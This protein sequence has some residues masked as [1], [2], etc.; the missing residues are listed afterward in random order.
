MRIHTET[1]IVGKEYDR[2]FLANL[3]G[4]RSFQALG[5]GVVTP[6]GEKVIILFITKDKQEALEQY[7]D[8]FDG[9]VLQMEGETN[10]ANDVRLSNSL[11]QDHV[12]L[13]YRERHH[14]PFT[15]KG[16]VFLESTRILTDQ[17]S[18][19]TFVVNNIEAEVSSAIQTDLSIQQEMTGALSTQSEGQSRTTQ[20]T[21]YRRS[22][23]N[24]INAI[25]FHGTKCVACGFDFNEVYG[26]ELAKSYIQVHHTRSITEI[27]G[28]E[29]NIESD[30]VP[31]CANCHCMVHRVSGEI[32]SIDELRS[33]ISR[34]Q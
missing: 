31:L 20:S 19:F 3:W 21:T 2:T 9:H 28:E 14:M 27:E 26:K 12:Y 34:N 15:F 8:S 5:R 4:Y 11:G 6:K 24:R 18:R 22:K 13:F 16:E 7:E 30:L 29:I 10:H 25:R 33:L 17:P 1:L 32:M 23:Q